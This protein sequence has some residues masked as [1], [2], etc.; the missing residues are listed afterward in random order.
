MIEVL[1]CDMHLY[2]HI[3]NF[4]YLTYFWFVY[5]V[6]TNALSAYR[7]IKKEKISEIKIQLL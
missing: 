5:I 3:H 4:Y 7:Q 2:T 1:E 6:A